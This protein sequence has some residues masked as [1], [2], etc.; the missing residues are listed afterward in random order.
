MNTLFTNISA[1]SLQPYWST[2]FEDEL[3]IATQQLYYSYSLVNSV[4]CSSLLL[5]M[6]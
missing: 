5:Y 3:Y 6:Q 4:L 2:K 1:F